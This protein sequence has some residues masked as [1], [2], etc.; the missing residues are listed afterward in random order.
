MICFS[1]SLLSVDEGK[2]NERV[3][4]SDEEKRVIGR[5]KKTVGGDERVASALHQVAFLWGNLKCGSISGHQEDS[6][7]H[8]AQRTGCNMIYVTTI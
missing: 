6:K 2:K 5:R 3:F 7:D 1:S 4:I 8:T